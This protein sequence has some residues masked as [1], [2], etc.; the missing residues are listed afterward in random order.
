M[1]L[2]DAALLA[3]QARPVGPA[4]STPEALVAELDELLNSA[5]FPGASAR[6]IACQG[7]WA[8]RESLL[9]FS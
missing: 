2:C 4:R 9:F 6:R 7:L 1:D 8:R 5:G 3:E